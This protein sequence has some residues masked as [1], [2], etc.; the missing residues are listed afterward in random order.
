MNTA[1]SLNV[2]VNSRF[3]YGH[4]LKPTRKVRKER[5][6][7]CVVKFF[8]F[9]YIFCCL[10][11][12]KPSFM[13]YGCV[14]AFC[15]LLTELSWKEVTAKVE[16]MILQR[17]QNEHTEVRK[18]K[19]GGIM[20]ILSLGMSPEFVV[21]FCGTNDMKQGTVEY[22]NICFLHNKMLHFSL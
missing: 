6:V 8:F 1:I 2:S 7:P 20:I 13:W 16:T 3:G 4:V 11:H 14:F 5:K 21:A 9:L 22:R 12:A 17:R 19:N 18:R 10:I 15:G